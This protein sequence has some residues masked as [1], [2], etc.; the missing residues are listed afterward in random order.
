[1]VLLQCWRWV[2]KPPVWIVGQQPCYCITLWEK[3]V[4]A[5][6]GD[7]AVC[8]N[9]GVEKCYV[10]VWYVVPQKWFVLPE[11]KLPSS[12]LP[13]CLFQY[14]FSPPPQMKKSISIPVLSS[15]VTWRYFLN[16]LIM[17]CCFFIIRQKSCCFS[18][19]NLHTHWSSP[20]MDWTFSVIEGYISV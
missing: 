14:P 17:Q 15:F 13:L 2:P 18:L 7:F 19:N 20:T 3:E 11:I 12:E 5:C 1:M 6:I 8:W 10:F 9:I 16:N 4:P